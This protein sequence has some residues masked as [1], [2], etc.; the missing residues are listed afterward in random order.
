MRL[1]DR[2]NYAMV[3]EKISAS[4]ENI[5][6]VC[7]ILLLQPLARMINIA[8]WLEPKN[9]GELRWNQSVTTKLEPSQ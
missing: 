6:S 3:F 7:G 8:L 4:L 2:S 1:D 5:P 9:R